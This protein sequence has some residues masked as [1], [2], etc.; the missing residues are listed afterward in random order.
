M[1][2]KR[3]RVRTALAAI[4]CCSI[5][6]SG[7]FAANIGGGTVNASALN[8]RA[9]ASTDSAITGVAYNGASVVVRAQAAD[10]W[11]QVWYNGAE[12]YM[13]AEYLNF[14]ETLDAE[15]GTGTIQGTE[16][17]L[18]AGADLSAQ[19]LGS[20]DTGT[21]MKVIG[22]SG[23]WYK[24]SYNGTEGY[25]HSDYMTLEALPGVTAAYA[26]YTPG[27]QIV[28][29]AMQYMGVPYVWAGTSPSGFDCSGLVYYCY[30]ENGYSINRTAASIYSNGVAVDRSELQPGDAICF[31][32]GSYSYIG[33]VGIYIGNNEFI[34]ASSSSGCVTINSLSENYYN[35]H[36]Y[37][38]RRIV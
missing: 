29:T 38:A 11:Y 34:H 2:K 8:L 13:S 19:I 25:V 31:T 28:N 17:R 32:D 18:R 15:L 30:K 35:N 5:L 10:G 26:A 37:G 22:V 3:A 6:V 23:E 27:Q 4:G 21:T 16:V 12:G 24:V 7:V 14:S 1:D 33:H 9:E 20:Y 36:Y